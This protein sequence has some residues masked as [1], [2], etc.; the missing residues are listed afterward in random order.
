MRGIIQ[1]AY[2]QIAIILLL[3]CPFI[4]DSLYAY[5]SIIVRI[6]SVVPITARPIPTVGGGLARVSDRVVFTIS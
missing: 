1:R 6:T 5:D 4:T 3:F 2:Q